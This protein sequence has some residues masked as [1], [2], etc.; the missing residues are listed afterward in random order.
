MGIRQELTEYRVAIKRRYN[1][2]DELK[3]KMLAAISGVFDDPRASARDLA[4]AAKVV[5]AAEQQNQTDERILNHNAAILEFA[6]RLGIRDEVE[7]IAAE[8]T[9]G[10]V[11]FDAAEPLRD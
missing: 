3:E 10:N 11:G 1:I 8:S 4:A 6:E 9:G 2:S 7:V 5:I